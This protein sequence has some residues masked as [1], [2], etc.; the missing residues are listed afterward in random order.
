MMM[1]RKPKLFVGVVALLG[2]VGACITPACCAKDE[3]TFD[4]GDKVPMYVNK[5]GPYFNTHETYHYYS[6]PV[7]RPDKVVSRSLT[8]GEVLDGDRMAEALHDIRF[9]E[10][11]PRT[12]LCTVRLTPSDIHTL[13]DAI[14]D[15]YYFEFIIDDMPVRGFLG[16]LEEHVIDFPNTYKTY[17]WTH[18]HFHL[19]YNDDRIVA[20]NVSE[21]SVEVE[22]PPPSFLAEAEEDTFDVTYTYSVEWSENKQISFKNRGHHGKPFFPHTL[23]IHW[24]SIINAAVLVVLLVGFV[25]VIMTKALNR[26]FARYSRDDDELD[27]G[28]DE[29][30]G[31]KII[32]SDVFRFPSHKSI[33]CAV[34]GNGIQF[35]TIIGLLLL[36]AVLGAF[37]VRRHH[38][39]STAG[40]L[41][42]VATGFVAGF[43]S[44]RLFVQLDGQGWAWNIVLTSC[45]FTLPFFI[46]WSFINS[47]AWAI[48]STQALPATTIILLMLIW[49]LIG[50]PLTV[51]GGI[52]GKNSAGSFNAPCRTKNIA[53]DIP[54]QPWYRA[55]ST[56]LVVGGFL[57]FSAISV[58]LY[59]I[60]ATVWGR[61]L[62]TLYGV[63]LLVFT[64]LLSVAAFFSIALTYFQLSGEDYRWWWRSIFASGFTGVFV[65]LY[66]IF[67]F[68]ERSNM[69]GMLQTV[70]YFGYLFIACYALFLML[71][72]VGF[73]SSLSFVRYIYKNVKLD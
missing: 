29:D 50:F 39:M 27:Q 43:F 54:L 63:L 21:K 48:G 4:K 19:Q 2:V 51:I 34:V 11:L 38:A 15:L 53:R 67:Y 49:V 8:L 68:V 33:L 47:V 30:Q 3:H 58:E 24:L 61:E 37:N 57:P 62:Y 40:V 56:Q 26:D 73:L 59:Y 69:S 46:S 1:M 20:V 10:N 16:Q 31:W 64:I 71:G 55:A 60:F 5:V 35:I 6:L 45:L 36:F 25:S 22:L 44:T 23:E 28:A 32:H 72:S 70:Q 13:R 12:D 41:L 52:V 14:D 7:C 17:L 18:M 65:F 9:R 66:G 42:Y